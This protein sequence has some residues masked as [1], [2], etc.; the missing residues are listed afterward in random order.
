MLDTETA[1]V[2]T[3]SDGQYS[4]ILVAPTDG[5][6]PDSLTDALTAGLP[7]GVE[8]KAR[9]NLTGHV[10]FLTVINLFRCIV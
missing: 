6:S 3:G 2:F 5:V 7:P 9:I 8:P 4:Y 10:I 1:Q